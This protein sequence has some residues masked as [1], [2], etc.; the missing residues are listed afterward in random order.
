[1]SQYDSSSTSSGS[2]DSLKK[3]EATPQGKRDRWNEEITFAEKELKKFH[4]SARRVNKRYIDDRDAVETN[5]RWFNVFN[6]NVGILEASLY[7]Q[8]PGVDVS[9]RFFDMDDDIARVAGIILQRSIEQDMSEPSCDFD[10]VMRQ[11]VSD[12]LVPGLG[13]AWLRLETET[14]DQ[15]EVTDE[16]GG[17]T[18]PTDEEGNPLQRISHQEVC[19]DYV[20]WEDFLWSPCRVWAE[21]RWTARR[22]P[23]TRDK[24]VERFGEDVGKQIPLDYEPKRNTSA[25]SGTP[26]N[27]ILKRACIYEIWD[28]ETRTVIWLSKGHSELLDVKE[29]PLGLDHFE[30]CPKPMFANLTTSS[31][32]PKPD[33]AMIQD[34][35]VEMDEVNNRIS[36]LIVACKVVGVYDRG[37]EGIQR[38]L[39]EGYDNTLIP[40]DNWAMFAEKGGVKGQID[41]L[42]LDVVTQALGQL[43][44]HREAIKAQIYELTG[45]SDIVRGASKASETLGAQELKSKFASVRIQK[46]QDEVT[47]F[48]QEILQ[49]KAEILVKHFDPVILAKMSN[50]ENTPDAQ[51]AV[52]ALQ[53]IKGN[54]EEMEWRVHI[55]ADALAMVDY[56]QQKNERSEFMNSVATFL[57]SSS[58]VGQGAPQLI[59]LMLELLKFGVAGFRVSKDVEGI[60]DKYIKEFNAE[61]EAKKNAPPQ[62][63][64]EQQKMQAEMQMK[65]QEAQMKQQ[66][67]VAKL[68][69]D[70]Q[71]QQSDIAME[72]QRGQL[73]L[74]QMQQEGAL[75]LQ[76]MQQEFALKME[77]MQAEADIKMQ[78]A[79]HDAQAKAVMQAQSHAQQMEQA[80]EKAEKEPANG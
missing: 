24:L 1:V 15:P 44:A 11:A 79:V 18:V 42:P 32:V 74:Q 40:V 38:M 8:I 50:I 37:A 60:F 57:Q 56:T 3:L 65:Q 67:E 66:S 62:P 61:L 29:D 75:K 64:P 51:M 54:E 73:E 71:K 5:Q 16:N 68:Q 78:V 22:V 47:R 39:T 53:L 41:W 20:F 17:M 4:E 23:M 21:R 10:Q 76:Q 30:P 58:T 7:A 6:T 77:Q 35:Y 33:Y 36:L 25:D 31:C 14:E 45:I 19:I 52:P 46:L 63:D 48:A 34:Q 70:Q 13:M 55:Q 80:D 27:T 9:R 2:I 43:Q 26:K 12:R 59:P 28:R 49:I 72:Q 69:M